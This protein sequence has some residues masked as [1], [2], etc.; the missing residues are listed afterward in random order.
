ML[1]FKD[2]L[3]QI[4]FFDLEFYVPPHDQMLEVKGFKS[5]PFK[6]DHLLLGGTFIKRFPRSKNK[7][8]IEKFW[9]WN[10]KD[11]ADL[12]R[13]IYQYFRD[14][15]ELIKK[16]PDQCDLIIS[17]IGVGRADLG[18]LYSKCI[19]Y[20]IDSNESLF[21]IFFHLRILDLE[22]IAIPMFK[23]KMKMMYPKN[24][25]ELIA[26][27]KLDTIRESGINVWPLYEQ[28]QFAAIEERNYI[29]V[30]DFLLIYDKILAQV[31]ISNISP[32]YHPVSIERVQSKLK[33]EEEIKDFLQCFDFNQEENRFIVTD[34]DEIRAKILL[35]FDKTHYWKK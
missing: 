12:L 20:A 14:S 2:S 15:W 16:D 11:E 9:F 35:Y 18:Y 1:R 17:G 33:S 8:Q 22:Q 21:E 6:Q 31:R 24:T 28:N 23:S 29:E 4:I 3:T 32:K 30:T 25:A 5:N 7:D 10:F 13:T 19:H 26:K 27:F 34:Q